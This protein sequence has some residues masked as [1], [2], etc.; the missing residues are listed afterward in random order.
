[1]LA[2]STITSAHLAQIRLENTTLLAVRG[3]D[4]VASRYFLEG[5]KFTPNIA[6]RRAPPGKK[7]RHYRVEE[8]PRYNKRLIKQRYVVER[9]NAWLKSFR[10]LHFHFDKSQLSLE[11]FLTTWR[12][13]WKPLAIT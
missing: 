10:K 3:Y 2:E 1:M 5:R 12:R 4:S 13:V 9:T 6:P 8:D 11:A 7:K